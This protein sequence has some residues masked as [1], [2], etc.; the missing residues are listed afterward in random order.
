MN[1]SNI[2]MNANA[3]WRLLSNNQ[4]W[5]QRDLQTA[6]G[7]SDRDFLLA[8]GWLAR[9]NRIEFGKDEFTDEDTLFL[10][11]NVYI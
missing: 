1:K 2:K 10:E 6:A 9:E 11:F 4:L 8:V 5:K 7:L 3:V